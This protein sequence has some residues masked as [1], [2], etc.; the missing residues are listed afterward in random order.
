MMRRYNS[1]AAIL[2]VTVAGLLMMNGCQAFK[3][4][5]TWKV[6]SFQDAATEQIVK[7][8]FGDK[9]TYLYIYHLI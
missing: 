2:L 4:M 8:R 1:Y 5:S 9:S 6:P 7:D 3:F